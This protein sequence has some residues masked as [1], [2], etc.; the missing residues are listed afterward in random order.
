MSLKED[1]KKVDAEF[2]RIGVKPCIYHFTR[3]MGPF[4]AITVVDQLHSW[5]DVRKVI[6]MERENQLRAVQ[7][8]DNA[9]SMLYSLRE[10]K[11]YGVAICDQRD[12]FDRRKGRVIAKGRLLKHLKEETK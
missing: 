3:Y 6:D 8:Y 4:G 2:E 10:R 12:N 5:A 9:S 1:E 11:I 7:I